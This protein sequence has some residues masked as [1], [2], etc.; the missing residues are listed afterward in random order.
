VSEVMVYPT[1][2]L[3]SR[4]FAERVVRV[5]ETAMAVRGRFVVVVSGGSTPRMAYE[6]LASDYVRHM[7]WESSYVFWG[8]ERGVPPESPLSNTRMVREALVNHVR[9]PL[10][11]VFRIKGELP[12]DEAARKYDE[13]LHD[14]FERRHMRTPRFD[15]VLLGMGADGHVASLLPG[16]PA[17]NE[18]KRWVTTAQRPDEPFAR[19]TLTYP[20]LNSAAHVLFLVTGADKA[21]I[22]ARAINGDRSHGEVP[23]HRI[24]PTDGTITWVLDEA[25]AKEL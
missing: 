12:A 6:M 4:G 2:A 10:D 18:T 25:A 1:H 3:A 19:I 23:V 5:S 22:A 20:A 11:R 13:Q 14:F 9:I 24:A 17:L 8:D 16:S 15:A 21:A 7:D